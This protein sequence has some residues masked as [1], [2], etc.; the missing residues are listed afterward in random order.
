MFA[1]CILLFTHIVACV[2]ASNGVIDYEAVR[3]KRA[4]DPRPNI[5]FIFTD[6]QDARMKSIDYMKGVQANL[7]SDAPT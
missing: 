7:V 6:D 2:A 1:K 5:V 3:V 4:A